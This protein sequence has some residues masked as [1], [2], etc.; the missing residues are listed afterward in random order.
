MSKPDHNLIKSMSCAIKGIKHVYK[1]EKNFRK[2]TFISII[3]I[4][5]SFYLRLTNT[6]L[7]IVVLV[8]ALVLVSEMINSVIEYTWDKLEPDHHPVIGII[9]DAMAGVVFQPSTCAVIVGF[10]IFAKYF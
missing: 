1:N 9:K 7:A 5:I 4:F 3:V 10:L 6:D 2:H 8:I